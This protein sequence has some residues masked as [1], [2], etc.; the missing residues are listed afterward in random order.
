[1]ENQ[2]KADD[3]EADPNLSANKCKK[4]L[5]GFSLIPLP[6]NNWLKIT[7]DKGAALCISIAASERAL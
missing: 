4:S 5:H 6:G 3:Q 2:Q 7:L 1:L